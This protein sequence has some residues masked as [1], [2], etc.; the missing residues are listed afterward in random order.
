MN[1]GYRQAQILRLIR[2]REI[3]TQ[4]ELARELKRLG[5]A[6]TQVTLSRDLRE[7]GLAKSAQG[8]RQIAASAP[9]P[10]LAT[11][12]EEFVQ[13]VRA[14]QSLVVVKTSP[15]HANSVAVSLDA[16]GWPEAVGT[17]A[18]DDTI[19]IVTPNART[20]RAVRRKLLA[21]LKGR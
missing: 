4:D 17:V 11:L 15:G 14:A 2:A 12:V 10:D 9:G 20:A 18:G 13:D 7:L 1:K 21:L 16:E 3:H 8:Y 19:L 5:I 6:A